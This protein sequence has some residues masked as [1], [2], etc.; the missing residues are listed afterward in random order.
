MIPNIF[1]KQIQVIRKQ[2][3][4][5]EKNINSP[6]LG[7][8]QVGEEI[9]F[10]IQAIVQPMPGD[11]TQILPEGY[12]DKSSYLIITDTELFCSEENVNNPDIVILYNKKYLILKKKIFDITH[13][14]HYELTAVELL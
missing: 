4:F 11:T 5:F 10:T 8:W 2:D 14:S 6:S 1:N 9:S 3:G 7:L 12:R 13:L